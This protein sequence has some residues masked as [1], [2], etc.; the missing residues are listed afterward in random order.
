[1]FFRTASERYAV[2]LDDVEAVHPVTS[3]A[4]VPGAPPAVRGVA[5][6]GGEVLAL[7][8]VGRLVGAA[9]GIEDLRRAVVVGRPPPSSRRAA[10]VAGEVEGIERVA[11][12]DLRPPPAAPGRPACVEA[13][14]L[15]DRLLLSV[16]GLLD[17]LD[18]GRK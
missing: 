15:G 3:F 10:L 16:E 8:D 5:P 9:R 4:A 1:L 7:V 12:A 11:D 2:R 17:A 18:P 13:V 6:I 14:V